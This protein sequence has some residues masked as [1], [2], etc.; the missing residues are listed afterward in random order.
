VGEAT[1]PPLRRAH[2]EDPGGFP[3]MPPGVQRAAERLAAPS[4]LVAQVL[5]LLGREGAVVP[6]RR[7]ADVIAG[8][9]ELAARLLRVANAG[10]PERTGALL[11]AV[12]RVGHE[13][14][15][16]MLLASET[17]PGFEHP[18][19]SYGLGRRAFLRHA[20]RVAELAGRLAERMAPRHVSQAH[21]AG[22]LHDLG[23]VL[24]QE[25]E[26]ARL[27]GVAP[28]VAV[29][30]WELERFRVSHDEV[31][32]WV[33]G[34]W[35]ALPAITDAVRSHHLAAPPERPLARAVWL[36]D[37]LAHAQDGDLDEVEAAIAAARACGI[38]EEVVERLSGV[39]LSPPCPFTP[40]ERE[41]LRALDALGSTVRAAAALGMS[42]ASLDGLLV[43]A[44]TRLGAGTP[45]QAL[46]IARRWGWLSG[47]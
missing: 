35:R 20:E 13:A 24:L 43:R 41:A 28:R 26:R 29:V 30:S 21:V 44:A 10:Y 47:A 32:A 6:A 14:L 25:D 42:R 4:P 7:L 19:P 3:E 15:S 2:G 31:A 33:C 11:Q 1:A 12:V 46:R 40:R 45:A 34:R 37:R 16:G 5:A 17:V 39:G 27:G 18:L 38:R 23:K 8:S 9:P 22:L 36:A